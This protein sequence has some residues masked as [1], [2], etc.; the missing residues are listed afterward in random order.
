M[1]TCSLSSA[2]ARSWRVRADDPHRSLE[3][4]A[5]RVRARG[6]RARARAIDLA[7]ARRTEHEHDLA[8]RG[9]SSETPS[10][11]ARAA[12]SGRCGTGIQ[13]SRSG[14]G[15]IGGSRFGA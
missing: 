15:V 12:P 14:A 8:A 1:A 10:G 9:M 4:G 7:A 13:L 6:R 3:V 2:T 5:D 11:V